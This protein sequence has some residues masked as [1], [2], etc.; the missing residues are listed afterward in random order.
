[1]DLSF[2]APFGFA[3]ANSLG[4][5]EIPFLDWMTIIVATVAIGMVVISKLFPANATRP[6]WRIE[7]DWSMFRVERSFALG[8]DHMPRLGGDLRYMVVST[9]PF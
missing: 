8:S 2:L 9:T 3:K 5:Y 6:T 7:I 4:A 1:M